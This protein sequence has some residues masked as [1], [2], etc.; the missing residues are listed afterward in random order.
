MTLTEQLD[1]F[2]ALGV[3]RDPAGS[4]DA[5]AREIANTLMRSALVGGPV[6]R[7]GRL[8]KLVSIIKRVAKIVTAERDLVAYSANSIWPYRRLSS[9]TSVTPST[10]QRW[11]EAGR[12]VLGTQDVS[13]ETTSVNSV[14]NAN[15]NSSAMAV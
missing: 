13:R 9:L 3:V 2:N 10:M 14:E 11:I 12:K 15:S 5:V 8:T 1:A 6:E 4:D 7:I